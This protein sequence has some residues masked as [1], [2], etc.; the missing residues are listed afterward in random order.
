MEMIKEASGADN[1]TEGGGKSMT[2]VS[3]FKGA[4]AL[5]M[6]ALVPF[7]RWAVSRPC[8]NLDCIVNCIPAKPSC[9]LLTA[10]PARFICRKWKD[11][12]TRSKST[13]RG[14]R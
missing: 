7:L 6:L 11:S 5:V 1:D 9:G 12:C 8:A 3:S 10:L 2:Q 13:F 4:H 14:R